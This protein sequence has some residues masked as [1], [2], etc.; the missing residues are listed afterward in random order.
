[1]SA[2][3]AI[4]ALKEHG[5]SSKTLVAV[6]PL[7]FWATHVDLA[8]KYGR[9]DLVLSPGLSQ[10]EINNIFRTLLIATNK[11]EHGQ[12]SS[13]LAGDAAEILLA[14]EMT[15]G[16]HEVLREAMCLSATVEWDTHLFLSTIQA[17]P[18]R[19]RTVYMRRFTK[20][21]RFWPS[22]DAFYRL[23][24]YWGAASH[25]ILSKNDNTKPCV[26]PDQYNGLLK[27]ISNIKE[28]VA[29]NR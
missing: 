22:K 6:C 16:R 4:K 10:T 25:Q 2:T 12:A 15:F 29:T 13:A 14:F 24:G 11:G 8:V 21:L 26:W 5:P 23:A 9:G 20:H 7:A 17:M 28:S 1:M 27:R 3:Q 19:E 18:E